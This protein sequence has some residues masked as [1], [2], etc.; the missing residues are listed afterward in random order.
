MAKI[1]N[2]SKPRVLRVPKECAGEYIA[3]RSWTSKK[4]IAH[5]KD[6]SVAYN[7]ARRQGVKN[8]V[9]MFIRDPNVAYLF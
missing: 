8:P 4:I 9:L 6:P 2:N 3:R 1:P 7:D 5:S